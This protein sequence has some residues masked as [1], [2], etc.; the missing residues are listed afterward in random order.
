MHCRCTLQS[1]THTQYSW[2]ASLSTLPLLSACRRKHYLCLSAPAIPPLPDPPPPGPG[3]YEVVDYAGDK[4]RASDGAMF[5]STTARW[6]VPILEESPGPGGWGLGAGPIKTTL[7][8]VLAMCLYIYYHVQ[9]ADSSPSPLVCSCATGSY[10]PR[11][12]EKQSFL[13]NVHRQWI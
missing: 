1:G 12:S 5:R 7:R 13:Y 10:F 6:E 11:A 8:I 3:A 9:F 2:P 4:K